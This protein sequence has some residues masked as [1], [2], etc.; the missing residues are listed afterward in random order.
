MGRERQKKKN[1]SSK[2]TVRPNSNRTKAGKK[3]VNFLGNE[4]I[5]KNWDRKL[6]VSQNYKRLGLSSKLNAATGGTEKKRLKDGETEKE[7]RDPFAISGP[8]AAA[9][10]A[11]QEVQ[12]ER[13]PETGRIVRVI[14]PETD[15]VDDNPLNDALNDIMDLDSQGPETRSKHDVVAQLEA[16]AAEEEEL[17]AT[18]RRPR[19]QSKREEEWIA[20]LVERYGDDIKAMVRD[21]KLNPMQQT[22]GDISR[23]I[24][25]WKASREVTT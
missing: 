22:E 25:K 3:K 15:D 18:K 7:T 4:T 11:S 20:N 1:R 13:D 6:T 2:P 24:R 14:R 5:A 16:Q 10:L 8:R 19:Q 23:R 12:V 9:K 21:R 17:L